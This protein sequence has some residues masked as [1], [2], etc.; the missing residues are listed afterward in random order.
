[1]N[2]DQKVLSEIHDE[3]VMEKGNEGLVDFTSWLWAKFLHEGKDLGGEMRTWARTSE[4][5]IKWLAK[6]AK[7]NEVYSNIP[8]GNEEEHD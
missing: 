2:A 8:E 7:K 4:T 6:M 1:M 3:L 5:G